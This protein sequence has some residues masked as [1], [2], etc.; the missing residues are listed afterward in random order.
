MR[1]WIDEIQNLNLFREE[2][3]VITCFFAVNAMAYVC[4]NVWHTLVGQ[5]V[6]RNSRYVEF[7]LTAAAAARGEAGGGG[8]DSALDTCD[9]WQDS[10]K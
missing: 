1:K 2:K 6:D 5:R 4:L 9:T 8:K 10:L 7:M 3:V